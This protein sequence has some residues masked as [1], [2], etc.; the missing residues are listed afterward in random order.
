[1]IDSG[2]TWKSHIGTLVTKL[3]RAIGVLYKSRSCA[4]VII[5]KTLYYSL[6]YSH[7]NYAIE[8]WGSADDVYL[9]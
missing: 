4:N 5:L 8:V 2:L 9:N 6:I 1:M 7:L 3:S